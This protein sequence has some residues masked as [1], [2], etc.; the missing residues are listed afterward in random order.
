MSTHPSKMLEQSWKFTNC[1]NVNGREDSPKRSFKK[2]NS[3]F[4]FCFVF[5]F[6]I[7]FVTRM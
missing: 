7:L 1:V 5:L 4:L 6:C 3:V 2:L